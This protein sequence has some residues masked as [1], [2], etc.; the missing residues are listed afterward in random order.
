MGS[1]IQTRIP[2]PFMIN[3]KI[4]CDGYACVIYA[5]ISD[6]MHGPCLYDSQVQPEP[7]ANPRLVC[8]SEDALRLLDIGEFWMAGN[9]EQ[10][11]NGSK[12]RPAD[13]ASIACYTHSTAHCIHTRSCHHH[14]SQGSRRH[15]D[16]PASTVHYTN[17]RHAHTLMLPPPQIPRKQASS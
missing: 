16:Q 15:W 4:M 5:D 17:A 8:Y 11:R 9:H 1:G 14:S 2:W 7:V 13:C 12:F 10:T 3:L 6:S